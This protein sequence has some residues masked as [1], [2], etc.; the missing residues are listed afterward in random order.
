[1]RILRVDESTAVDGVWRLFGPHLNRSGIAGLLASPT[2]HLLAAFSEEDDELGESGTPIGVVLG[3]E[4]IGADLSTEMFIS[5]ITVQPLVQ[6]LGVGA[7]LVRSMLEVASERGCARVRGTIAPDNV[8]AIR[9]MRTLGA[10]TEN[11]SINASWQLS[12]PQDP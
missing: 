11:V 1:M 9:V 4:L 5:F 6:R 7:A 12:S 10:A 3:S 8:G 2:S